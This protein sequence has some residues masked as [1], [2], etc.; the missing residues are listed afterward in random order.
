MAQL[1]VKHVTPK[2][3]QLHH[4][5]LAQVQVHHHLSPQSAHGVLGQHVTLGLVHDL[6]QTVAVDH[7]KLRPV[8]ITQLVYQ[9][10][11][12]RRGVHAL[13]LVA[14]EQDLVTTAVFQAV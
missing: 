6:A 8:Q 4:Q 13:P 11:R 12:S 2:L 5:P 3:V 10:V 9:A 7:L 14:L 1:P